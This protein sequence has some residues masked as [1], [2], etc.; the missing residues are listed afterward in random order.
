VA[1]QDGQLRIL[2]MGA[3][4]EEGDGGRVAEALMLAHVLRLVGPAGPGSLLRHAWASSSPSLPPAASASACQYLGTLHRDT[5]IV[6]ATAHPACPP[7][8]WATL[9][10]CAEAR[11]LDLFAYR[12]NSTTKDCAEAA[13]LLVA[14]GGSFGLELHYVPGAPPSPTTV[15]GPVPPRRLL[16][17]APV[18]LLRFSPDGRWLAV[19]CLD[20]RIGVLDVGAEGLWP[21]SFGGEDEEPTSTPLPSSSLWPCTVVRG[22][23]VTGLEF[24]NGGRRLAVACADGN[25]LML[26][27]RGCR[28]GWEACPVFLAS[29]RAMRTAAA[30]SMV[31]CPSL[32][33]GGSGLPCW[34][35]LAW[36]RDDSCLA[37][38]LPGN[39]LCPPEIAVLDAESGARIGSLPLARSV[40]G[41][42]SCP[43]PA[44]SFLQCID[45]VGELHTFRWAGPS[46]GSRKEGPAT[47]V[48][49]TP[50]AV[51]CRVG[52]GL[53]MQ[54]LQ[55]RRRRRPATKEDQ[56]QQQ[57]QEWESV[58]LAVPFLPLDA[59]A[60]WA[61]DGVAAVAA[62]YGALGRV[63]VGEGHLGLL[64][65]NMVY[66]CD[67]PGQGTKEEQQELP[68]WRVLE[69]WGPQDTDC[70]V[71]LLAA[72]FLGGGRMLAV[73]QQGDEA[74]LESRTLSPGQHAHAHAHLSRLV[75]PQGWRH[76]EATTARWSAL[77]SLEAS[78]FAV[79]GQGAED[80]VLHVWRG[81][82]SADGRVAL[83]DPRGTPLRVELPPL[84][85]GSS[86]VPSQLR[87]GKSR[88]GIREELRLWEVA[89]EKGDG[90]PPASSSSFPSSSSSS[91][92]LRC[93]AL[94]LGIRAEEEGGE[95]GDEGGEAGEG[96]F[97]WSLVASNARG[98]SQ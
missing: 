26:R 19:A 72:A 15:A 50:T 18:S 80:D 48:A 36:S 68:E 51:V 35:A 97:S 22:E 98:S 52:V 5:V 34:P 89:A 12:P 73:L 7:A 75:L 41:M 81:A 16:P 88:V 37:A 64:F 92:L 82:I 23:R 3:F 86:L 14:V 43:R 96:P 87:V 78:A 38:S 10:P 20:G 55:W 77:A 57:Q 29:L 54:R 83:A 46:V 61:E 58:E 28:G 24:A 27:C 47:L 13:A 40:Q 79:V 39:G 56:Q 66:V 21:P 69:V 6:H 32:M 44:A 53:E 25:V 11:C 9:R 4:L 8:P 93:W 71:S 2:A 95:E 67:W 91:S 90:A 59:L 74:L 76:Q 45:E 84:G 33:G 94:N 31:A 42:S 30:A 63:V 1:S 17:R 70:D 49:R 60:S 62:S 85:R 65:S